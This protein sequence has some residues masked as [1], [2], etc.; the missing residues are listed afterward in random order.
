M[1]ILV[2]ASKK[3]KKYP[4]HKVD[5]DGYSFHTLSTATASVDGSTGHD[6]DPAQV[7]EQQGR[8]VPHVPPT[9]SLTRLSSIS[10]TSSA[11]TTL[12]DSFSKRPL[13]ISQEINQS[14]HSSSQEL[15]T[16]MPNRSNRSIQDM[17]VN[18]LR[19]KELGLHG[20]DK[21][22][23]QLVQCLEHVV[24]ASLS[25]HEDNGAVSAA[26]SSPNKQVVWVKGFSGTGKSRLITTSLQDPVRRAGGC[27]VRG[28]FDLFSC[29]EPYLAWAAA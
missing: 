8:R 15:L 23:Q 25:S 3:V 16:S 21:E 12:E 4:N 24:L 29:Q 10:S 28:K 2:A 7:V 26:V 9:S 17:T 5:L 27:F 19:F 18:K 20:R 1:P 6:E 22:S 11:T 14:I 13:D